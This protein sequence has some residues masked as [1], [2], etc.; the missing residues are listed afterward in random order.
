MSN[1]IIGIKQADGTFYPI[2]REGQPAGRKLELTTVHN[3]QTTAQVNLYRSAT[4]SMDD[5][6]YVDTLLIENLVPHEKNENTINLKIRIDENNILSAEAGNP[7]TGEAANITV[8]LVKLDKPDFTASNDDDTDIN[9]NFGVKSTQ[10]FFPETDSIIS[11]DVPAE[12]AESEIEDDIPTVDKLL[13]GK[14]IPEP[15]D[16]ISQDD[17][18]AVFVNNSEPIE[19]E[20]S[21]ALTPEDDFSFEV[22]NDAETEGNADGE[23]GDDF[24]LNETP[25]TEDDI[26]L[27][28]DETEVSGADDFT[29][30][31]DFDSALSSEDGTADEGVAEEEIAANPMEDI[32]LDETPEAAPAEDIAV[33]EATDDASA[34]EEDSGLADDFSLPDD[35]DSI[36][37]GEENSDDAF[38]TAEETAA[39][40]FSIG[41]EPAAD[42]AGEENAFMSAGTDDFTLPDFD[43]EM[44]SEEP[45]EEA[46]A[47]D[48]PVTEDDFS[49]D[50][51][52]TETAFDETPAEDAVVTDDDF[53]I[54]ETPVAEDTAV[55]EED[56]ALD[57]AVT[58]EDAGEETAA[59][60]DG[61]DFSIGETSETFDEEVV[62]PDE[63]ELVTDE[64]ITEDDAMDEDFALNDMPSD[65]ALAGDFAEDAVSEDAAAEETVSEEAP[66]ETE[67]TAD[68]EADDFTLPDFDVEMPAEEPA[69]E[70]PAED[71]VVTDDDFA[72]DETPVAED[73]AVTEENAGE[74]AE[75]DF[76]ID[77]TAL[78][79]TETEAAETEAPQVNEMSFDMPDFDADHIVSDT[80]ET[81]VDDEDAPFSFDSLPDFDEV[82]EAREDAKP[83]DYDN[84]FPDKDLFAENYH[85]EEKV[86]R[87]YKIPVLICI[88]CAIISVLVLLFIL[89]LTPSRIESRKAKANV[90]E[91][92]AEAVQ[93]IAEPEPVVEEI[94]EVPSTKAQENVIVVTPEP[95]VPELPPEPVKKPAEIRHKIR[96][97]DTLWDIADTY[98][99]NPWLYK[100]I[101]R[102]NGIKNPD[103]IIS[104][105]YITISPL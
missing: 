39:D 69:E 26:A 47:E 71:A 68:G 43:V 93:E 105:T 70:T 40:D 76:S 92:V 55:T 74:E 8:S 50:G 49:L 42:A 59:V 83:S 60:E 88:I 95:V 16:D 28:G 35:F 37:A 11:H 96:W 21:Q 56:I 27:D 24:D 34:S 94:E 32:V 84:E 14:E 86:S 29:L 77:E 62:M 52:E 3:G 78:D 64:E 54:E 15:A 31:D 98:Y 57:D 73:T 46:P 81:P 53:A 82:P 45:A 97:G 79:G 48:I 41:E 89:Y 18:N 87:K 1:D 38:A 80:S 25:V 66:A 13:D 10:D 51:L 2:L 72:I 90:K 7:E 101:A 44:P 103:L 85:E 22:G 63:N 9:N 23:A 100:R 5:A 91:T 102:E 33:T 17:L 58:E 4:G 12:E 6:E 19:G 20:D 30:P 36:P 61:D 65:E 67:E 104:G 75:G 99:K